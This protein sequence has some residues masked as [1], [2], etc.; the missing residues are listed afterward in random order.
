MQCCITT[1]QLKLFIGKLLDFFKSLPFLLLLVLQPHALSSENDLLFCVFE[2]LARIFIYCHLGLVCH[3]F[4]WLDHFS[5]FSHRHRQILFLH[6]RSWRNQVILGTT[7]CNHRQSICLNF[8]TCSLQ[9][10]H[11]VI[12]KLARILL[13]LP[14]ELSVFQESLNTACYLGDTSLVRIT[15]AKMNRIGT[16]AAHQARLPFTHTRRLSQSC[17]I[18]FYRFSLLRLNIYVSC[19][20]CLELAAVLVS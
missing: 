2:L 14:D 5:R 17:F 11:L 20:E 15:L 9:H 16:L 19:G 6:Q 13:F 8:L 1:T 7:A 4:L 12:L 3:L 18:F 10:L